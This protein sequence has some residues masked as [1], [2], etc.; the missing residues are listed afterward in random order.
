MGEELLRLFSSNYSSS[1]SWRNH[2]KRELGWAVVHK[3]SN[4]VATTSH[5]IHSRNSL[6]KINTWRH[7][8]KVSA[9]WTRRQSRKL[10]MSVPKQ[11]EATA[12][13]R[14]R[15]KAV[16]SDLQQPPLQI[17][18]TQQALEQL[19]QMVF[20]LRTWHR[21][22]WR[23]ARVRMAKSSRSSLPW[24]CTRASP[25][26]WPTNRTYLRHWT[27]KWWKDRVP[28]KM[29]IWEFP[30]TTPTCSRQSTCPPRGILLPISLPQDH[31]LN[32]HQLCYQPS[33]VETTN[34]EL[35]TYIIH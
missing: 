25:A 28:N 21:C 5:R 35:G 17:S 20:I 3:G 4:R 27:P 29:A 13:T 18:I 23:R 7:R 10:T 11:S 12:K 26:T 1:C 2:S 6:P 15:S 31:L 33:M 9:T 19:N 32:S 16:I 22:C 30:M 14:S 24:K 34:R 8:T